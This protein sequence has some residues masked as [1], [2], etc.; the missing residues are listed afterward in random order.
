MQLTQLAQQ[1]I[2][3]RLSQFDTLPLHIMQPNGNS[4]HLNAFNRSSF[5][6]IASPQNP[7]TPKQQLLFKWSNTCWIR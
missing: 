6:A 7:E 3:N 4:L 2:F 1:Y 5:S